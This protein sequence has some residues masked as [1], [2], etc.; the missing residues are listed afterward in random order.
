MLKL[1]FA[2]AALLAAHSTALA[3]AC[4]DALARHAQAAGLPS[5]LAGA[6]AASLAI[7]PGGT[8]EPWAVSADGMARSENSPRAAA[9]TAAAMLDRGA[10]SVRVGCLGATVHGGMSEAD[11]L[12]AI[13]PEANVAA[14]LAGISGVMAESDI[15]E[16]LAAI[17][18]GAPTA[19]T[20]P[21][22][23]HE[24]A[25]SG[26]TGTLA[27]GAVGFRNPGAARGAVRA[28]WGLF[29][30]SRPTALTNP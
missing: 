23:Q 6:L 8:M 27:A 13:D 28:T 3:S 4:D 5:S 11:I 26:E 1:T 7:G 9:R 22:A 18:S 30:D 14:A 16:S 29:S 17:S 2:A 19:A 15:G 25:H 12:S 24:T 20:S 21:A 10:L